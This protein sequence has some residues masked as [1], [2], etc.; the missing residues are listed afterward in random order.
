MKKLIK[1]TLG[2]AVLVACGL[3]HA[4]PVYT[5][6]GAGPTPL[7]GNSI[8]DT[9]RGSAS[10]SAGI[11]SLNCTLTVTGEVSDTGTQVNLDIYSAS[12][13]GSLFLCSLVTFSG[14]PW[15]GSVDYT[16]LPA[17]ANSGQDI[18]FTIGT[19]EVDSPCG[20]CK[21]DVQVTFNEN[22]ANPSYFEFAGIDGT[23]CTVSG[24][25]TSLNG[26]DYDIWNQ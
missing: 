8:T 18:E 24:R 7:A 19:V 11:C 12:S 17:N 20:D 10:L 26:N 25:L 6:N 3:S 1:L 15:S 14:F 2:T 9:F 5:V 21:G 22:G 16:D 13:T 23:N 4:A